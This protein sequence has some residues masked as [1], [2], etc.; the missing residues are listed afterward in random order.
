[1]KFFK[2]ILEFFHR[3]FGG[4]PKKFLE[5]YAKPAI[6]IVQGVRDLVKSDVIDIATKLLPGTWDD[7]LKEKAKAALDKALGVL[8][9]SYDCLQKGTLTEKLFCFI[10]NVKAISPAMR[11]AVYAKL[12]SEVAK[13]LS[14]ETGHKV[15]SLVQMQFSAMKVNLED[16]DEPQ[17]PA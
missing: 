12:A 15:D 2:K 8:Q 5:N 10:L 13:E 11:K 6:L 3:L 16:D 1:M 17:T 4:N 9:L 14:G 7:D